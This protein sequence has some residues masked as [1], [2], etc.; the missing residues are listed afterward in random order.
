MT[1]AFR[2]WAAVLLVL[3]TVA[4]AA[5]KPNGLFCDGAVLQRGREIPVWGTADRGEK[6]TVT[7][8]GA[9]VTATAT[10]GKWLVKLPAQTAGG[11]D[12][13]TIAGSD[14]LVVKD[15]LVGE[16]W[17]CSGQSNMAFTMKGALNAEAEIASSADPLLRHLKV[18]YATA[19]EPQTGLPGQVKWQ[20]AS[21]ETTALFSATGYY[22]A[23]KLRAELGVPVG[24]LNNAVGG[25]ACAAWTRLAAIEAVPELEHYQGEYQRAV[26]ALPK[27]L[28][29]QAAKVDAWKEKVKAWREARAAALKENKPFN[30]PVPRA[31]QPPGKNRPSGLYN[32]LTAPLIPYA[33]AGAIWYQGENDTRSVEVAHEYRVL[34]P[35]M[36]KDW[37]QQW[38]QGDFPFLFVQLA[39]YHAKGRNVDSWPLVR[40]AMLLTTETVPQTGMSVITDAGDATNIHPTQKQPAGERLALEALRIAYGKD[41][42]SRGPVYRSKKIEGN[43]IRLSFD[44]GGGGLV[45]QGGPLKGFVICGEDHNF[46]AA[47]A[48]IEGETVVVS[49]PAVAQPV[50]V[51]YAWAPVPDVNFA[52]REGIPA[53]PFRTDDFP[54]SEETLQ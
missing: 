43:A 35:T 4:G 8:R 7:F 28:E 34:F 10:D 23:K 2:R 53:S 26:E 38:G 25:T 54:P 16:V 22:F 32:A 44:S 17:V 3:A 45:A 46:V 47:Q 36:I 9:S 42:V 29:Q 41:L 37:R 49:S 6:I 13:L 18:P 5:V 11:P 39:P 1:R 19:D 15:V 24:L 50:A 30:K 21:P 12:E 48:K 31:P 52:N 14:T 51:R 20:A 33:I 40:E 27:Q